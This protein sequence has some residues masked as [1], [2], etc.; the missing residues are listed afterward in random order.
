MAINEKNISI[1]GFIGICIS[2][3]CSD[4]VIHQI[5]ISSPISIIVFFSIFERKETFKLHLALS[6]KCFPKKSSMSLFY[7][8][9]TYEGREIPACNIFLYNSIKLASFFWNFK[10]TFL[11][12]HFIVIYSKICGTGQM[13]TRWANWSLID[14]NSLRVPNGHE[15]NPAPN[16]FKEQGPFQGT[17]SQSSQPGSARESPLTPWV[18][19]KEAQPWPGGLW[20]LSLTQKILTY[21]TAWCACRHVI[22][23][24]LSKLD[25]FLANPFKDNIL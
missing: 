4:V 22:K 23:S 9:L 21:F 3:I 6:S 5:E 20:G 15:Q 1:F 8:Y 13:S 14:K 2:K 17:G 18:M 7:F 11:L 25:F 10:S 12:P 19:Y 16:Y 24:H